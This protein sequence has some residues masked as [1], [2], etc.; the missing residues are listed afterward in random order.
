MGVAP[1]VRRLD[2]A[3]LRQGQPEGADVGL[4]VE[5]ARGHR[6]A[7]VGHG[8]RDQLAPLGL[9]RAL[10]HHPEHLDRGVVGLRARVDEIDPR[11]LHRRDLHQLLGEHHRRQRGPPEEGV[12]GRHLLQRLVG[13]LHQPRLA[14]AHHHVPQARD[15]FEIALAMRVM[16]V[17]T[18]ASLQHERA[19][20]LQAGKMGEGMKMMR[21]IARLGGVQRHRSGPLSVQRVLVRSASRRARPQTAGQPSRNK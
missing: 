11:D 20:P 3:H 1:V 15:A 13:R 14:E 19:V 9:A 16:D 4:A 7:V 2:I 8:A 17:D 5:A 18:F 12:I 21:E 10:R 6:R